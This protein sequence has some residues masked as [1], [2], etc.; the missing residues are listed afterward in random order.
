MWYI[1]HKKELLRGRWVIT[2]SR[3]RWIGIGPKRSG[4][5]MHQ[6]WFF[7]GGGF[8]P[9]HA[10]T[11]FRV[12][13]EFGLA[14]E[15]GCWQASGSYRITGILI[16][17]DLRGPVSPSP[18]ATFLVPILVL[19]CF[20]H[21]LLSSSFFCGLYLDSYK[22]IPKRNYYGAHGCTCT[23]HLRKVLGLANTGMVCP[24]IRRAKFPGLA[25]FCRIRCALQLGTPSSTVVAG[26]ASSDC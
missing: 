12:S 18:R 5:V 23:Q 3:Y 2:A 10:G 19:H 20:G 11:G 8:L 4:T 16:L 26:L 6:D 14:L 15:T 21:G 24:Q 22:A 1:N 7:F 13:F 25:T 17:S 9:T